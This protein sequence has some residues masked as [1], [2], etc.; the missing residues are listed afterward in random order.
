M[1]NSA[2]SF[3]ILKSE[4]EKVKILGFSGNLEI[5]LNNRLVQYMYSTIYTDDYNV[6]T[7][8]RKYCNILIRLKSTTPYVLEINFNIKLVN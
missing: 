5:D 6:E 4:L 8:D 1:F 7:K 3:F 2:S